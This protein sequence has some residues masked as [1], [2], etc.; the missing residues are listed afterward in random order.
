M[1]DRHPNVGT[2]LMCQANNIH[3]P[4]LV[5][6]GQGNVIREKRVLSSLQMCTAHTHTQKWHCCPQGRASPIPASSQGPLSLPS[7]VNTDNSKTTKITSP[8]STQNQEQRHVLLAAASLNLPDWPRSCTCPWPPSQGHCWS[9]S[10]SLTSHKKHPTNVCV[11]GA[12]GTRVGAD[13]QTKSKGKIQPRQHTTFSLLFLQP[14]EKSI[15]CSESNS[16]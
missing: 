1:G 8:E 3:V 4:G 2:W 14:W 15:R 10:P 6:L 11:A 9:L 16:A 7:R 13:T 5:A 12:A